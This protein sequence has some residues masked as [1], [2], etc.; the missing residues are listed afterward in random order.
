VITVPATNCFDAIV[1]DCA[2]ATGPVACI[3][4]VW[5]RNDIASASAHGTLARVGRPRIPVLERA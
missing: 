4:A 5:L 3:A 2:V 1:T